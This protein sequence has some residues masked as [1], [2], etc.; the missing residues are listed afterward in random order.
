MNIDIRTLV[1]VLGITNFLQVIAIFLQYLINKSYRGIGWWL[2]AFLSV[3]LGFITALLRDVVSIKLISIIITNILTISGPLFIYIGITRFL[4]KKEQRGTIISFLVIFVLFC[5]YFTYVTDDINA[6]TVILSVSLSAISFLTAQKLY[7]NK[8]RS[9]AA[10]ANFLSAGWLIQGL[11]FALRGVAT[12][13]VAPID[14]YFT[15]T[16]MQAVTYLFTLIISALITFGLIIMV[17]QRLYAEM[18][19][20]KEHFE[21]IFHTSPDAALITR[22]DDG[23]IVNV[24]EGF[25]TLTGFTGAETIGKSSLDVKIWKNPADRQKAIAELSEK[26]FCENIEAIFQ[27][28]DGGQI[29]GSLSARTISLQGIPHVISVTHD[30]SERVRSEEQIRQLNA[31]LEQRVAQRT[32]H[33]EAAKNEIASFTYSISHDLRIPVRAI[34]GF[35]QILVDEYHRQLEPEGQRLLGV[36]RQNTHKLDQIINE[37]LALLQVSQGELKIARIDMT[38]LVDSVYAEIASPEVQAKFSFMLSPLLEVDGEP[39][40]LRLVWRNLLSNAIKFTLP[41]DKPI[42]RVSSALEDGRVIYSIKDNGVGFDPKY[43]HKLFGLFE[44]LHKVDQFEGNGIGLAIVLRVVQRHG[45]KV[46]AEGALD[47]GATFYFSLPGK[48][49]GIL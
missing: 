17:N 14:N 44:R 35:S 48:A 36:I 13:T 25:T 12:L 29:I 38:S 47:L 26:G 2:L 16:W 10:S 15:P 24:N 42:I 37:M 33:L 34:D 23:L 18:R 1:I 19:E 9:I 5:S 6:R 49:G 20:S 31:E 32:A 30:I 45:G 3:A 7:A 46:W 11:F 21:L 43:I 41:K 4:G 28:K 8:T 27:R 40:L 39:A 22:L